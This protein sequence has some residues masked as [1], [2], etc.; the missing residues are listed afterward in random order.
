M[1]Q[2]KQDILGWIL[3]IRSLPKKNIGC[4]F[5]VHSILGKGYLENECNS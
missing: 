4:T 2:D 5:K 3:K 1:F